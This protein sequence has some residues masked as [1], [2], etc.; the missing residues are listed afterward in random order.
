MVLWEIDLSKFDILYRPA[1]KAQAL[2]DFVVK[3]IAKEDEDEEPATWMVQK[4]GLSNQHGGGIVVVLQSPKGDLIECAVRLHFPMINNEVEY[5][6]VLTGLDLAK[7]A[8]ALSIVIHNDSQ[9]I[10]G[11]INRDYEAKGE[12][13]KEYL[14]MV[15]ERIS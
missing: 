15:K 2:A 10:I 9:A 5:K 4:D 11:H 3:F 7:A 8:G 14:S 1:I 6:A 13:M 12:Q